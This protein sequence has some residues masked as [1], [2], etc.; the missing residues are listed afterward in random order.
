[1]NEKWRGIQS[2]RERGLHESERG[3]EREIRGGRERAK[4]SRRE[5]ESEMER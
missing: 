5:I 1:M 2:V 3:G 4:K